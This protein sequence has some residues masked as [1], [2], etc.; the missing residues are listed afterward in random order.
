MSKFNSFDLNA[1]ISHLRARF[2]TMQMQAIKNNI[3]AV[4]SELRKIQDECNHALAITKS[5]TSEQAAP[6]FTGLRVGARS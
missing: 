6:R 3:F 2:N 4:E 1:S 5:M